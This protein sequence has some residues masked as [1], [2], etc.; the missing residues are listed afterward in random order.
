MNW[1]ARVTSLASLS[2]AFVLSLGLFVPA[3]T[4]GLPRAAVITALI[5]ILAAIHFVGVRY[6]A[7][8][9]YVFTFGKLPR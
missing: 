1:I 6:G 2:N 9:I 8:S 7:A 3:L 4:S 5:L